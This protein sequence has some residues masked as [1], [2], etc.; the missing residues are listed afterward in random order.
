[1][2]SEKRELI[3]IGCP[4]GCLL[5]ATIENEKVIDVKGYTCL[6][7][8]T[9]AEKEC[10]NPTRIVTTTVKVDGGDINAVSVKTESDI[11]KEKISDCIKELRGKTVK[12]PIK[13]GDVIFE[14]IANTGVNIIAT[15][16]IKK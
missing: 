7:G 13:I 4:M 12:A 14:N 2:M 9:Y 11:P 6:K 15:K 8:K 1:M 3:C 5:E 10:T 16:N